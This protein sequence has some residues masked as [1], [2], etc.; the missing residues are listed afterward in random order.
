MRTKTVLLITLLPA[1]SAAAQSESMRD[2]ER[3]CSRIVDDPRPASI[4]ANPV[5]I[6]AYLGSSEHSFEGLV[7][8]RERAPVEV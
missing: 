1:G 5:V 7:K 6:E 4:Q 8:S 3:M 2:L